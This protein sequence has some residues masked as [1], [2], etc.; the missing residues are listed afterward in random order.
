MN[1]KQ[2]CHQVVVMGAGG[3]GALF[4][5]IVQQGG[6]EVTLVDVHDEH[7]AAI[8]KNGLQVVG[9]GGDRI[10]PISATTR[11]SEVHDAD[12][13]FFQCKSMSSKQAAKSV[14]HLILSL[15]HI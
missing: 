12:V 1:D 8:Q 10:V 13:V 15:I 6:L 9:F 5:S 2:A 11:A 3:M 14:A 4:G 7:V